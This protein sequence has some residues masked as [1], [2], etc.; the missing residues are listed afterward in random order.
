MT[1]ARGHGHVT[2]TMPGVASNAIPTT[3][4]RLSAVPDSVQAGVV[5]ASLVVVLLWTPLTS[6]GYFAPADILQGY[7]VARVAP[8]GYKI[9]N[10]VMGDPVF[11]MYPWLNWNKAEL[12][13]GRLPVWNPYN[14]V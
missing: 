2:A 11:Q 9:Q 6:G 12:R 14:G 1:S 10:P 8:E 4:R 13:N 3:R 5:L 7:E